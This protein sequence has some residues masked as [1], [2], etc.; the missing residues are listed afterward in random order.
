MLEIRLETDGTSITGV[1]IIDIALILPA[2]NEAATIQAVIEEFY[3]ELPESFIAVIDNNSSDTT[4]K[5][6]SETLQRLGATGIVIRELRQG[7]G[8]AVRRAFLEIDADIYVLVDADSTYPATQVR[9]LIQP[10]LDNNADM[11]VG[12]RFSG[13]HYQVENKRNLHGLGNALV[14]RLV[15][16][17]FQAKLVDIMSGYR[18]FSRR[19][20]K[21]YPILIEGFQ[22]ETDLTL[23][24]LDKRF[25]ILEIPVAYKDRPAGS[26]SKLNTFSD[27]TRVLFTIAQILRFYRPLFFFGTFSALFCIAG[28]LASMPVFEDWFRYRYI[29]HVPLALLAAALEIVA[30]MSM[31]IGLVLDSMAHQERMRFERSL[32]SAPIAR[33][34]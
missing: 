33:F 16:V 6:A 5:I 15:N 30:S 12:D 14:K 20:V 23:H 9:E 26:H 32:L 24:A 19:F 29:Y 10:V 22:L 1:N 8:N 7:K 3:R 17:F 2:Y 34:Q 4:A 31:G 21:H 11:V 27:G 18:V 13:G 28:L 25:R